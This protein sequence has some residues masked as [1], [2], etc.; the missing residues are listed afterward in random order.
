M[1][2]KTLSNSLLALTNRSILSLSGVEKVIAVSEKQL[3]LEVCG[4]GLIIEGN[5]MN[6]QK[7]DVDNGIIEIKGKIDC[8]KYQG[9]KE[10]T[11]LLKRIFK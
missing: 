10:K 11:S 5:N 7:L 8:I 4:S 9:K 6:V 1:E 2:T 3:S